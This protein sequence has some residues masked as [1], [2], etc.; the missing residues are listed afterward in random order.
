MDFSKED[1]AC[2]RSGDGRV[3]V[4]SGNKG[5]QSRQGAELDLGKERHKIEAKGGKGC[6][7]DWNGGYR[8][9][10]VRWKEGVGSEGFRERSSTRNEGKEEVEEGKPADRN[11]GSQ[12]I[13]EHRGSRDSQNH[14]R[15]LVEAQRTLKRL[16]PIRE[17]KEGE[18]GEKPYGATEIEPGVRINGRLPSRGMVSTRPTEGAYE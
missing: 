9:W 11:Q 6:E 2:S 10:S 4:Q 12:E 8:P 7:Y 16:R 18:S 5:R 1:G 14:L 13:D 17:T 15:S 3:E